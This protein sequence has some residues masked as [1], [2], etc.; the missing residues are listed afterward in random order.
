SRAPSPGHFLFNFEAPAGVRLSAGRVADSTPAS[1]PATRRAEEWVDLGSELEAAS[2]DEARHAYEQAIALDPALA[3]AHVNLGRLFHHAGLTER[4]ETHYRTALAH[5]PRDPIA[6]FNL[7]GLLE[8]S[9]RAQD[10]V[11]H[12]QPGLL[13]APL[14]RR[15]SAMTH[16]RAARR[17]YGRRSA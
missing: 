17:L 15:T 13:L 11:A 12:Y 16:L 7:A 5:A 8:E 3:D 9:G 2:P 14:G 1:P 6:H 10:A 4:A